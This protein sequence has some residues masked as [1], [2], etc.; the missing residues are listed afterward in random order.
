MFVSVQCQ[1]VV[2][3]CV[4]H[5]KVSCISVYSYR[6]HAGFVPQCEGIMWVT[7]AMNASDKRSMFH[8]S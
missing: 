2:S 4:G 6:V 8:H 3:Q 5:M 7:E 1:C